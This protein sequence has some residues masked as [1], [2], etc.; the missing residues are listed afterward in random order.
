MLACPFSL[1]MLQQLV[2]HMDN[3][4]SEVVIMGS[5][6]STNMMLYN[7]FPVADLKKEKLLHHAISYL[8]SS[9]CGLYISCKKNYWPSLAM[10]TIGSRTAHISKQSQ[11]LSSNCTALEAMIVLFDSGFV[12]KNM[13]C[14]VRM[15]QTVCL[16][17]NF[18]KHMLEAVK[19][20]PYDFEL[21]SLDIF[22]HK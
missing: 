4:L 11:N 12:R 17:L 6:S 7:L 5:S 8:V 3:N 10:S 16:R 18:T 20:L 14:F 1:F 9:A 19:T 13:H 22:S 21:N 15:I 2:L